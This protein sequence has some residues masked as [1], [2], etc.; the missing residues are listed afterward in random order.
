MVDFRMLPK[1]QV[2]ITLVLKLFASFL[3]HNKL[4]NTVRRM[5]MA[6]QVYFKLCN[7]FLKNLQPAVGSMWARLDS[8]SLTSRYTQGKS[9]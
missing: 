5:E 6:T 7:M 2:H 8:Q 3:V 1:A 4:D 9:H